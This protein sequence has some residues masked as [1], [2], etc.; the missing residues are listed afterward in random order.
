VSGRNIVVTV[1][2]EMQIFDQQVVTARLALE[3][4][5]DLLKRFGLKLST[6]RKGPSAFARPNMSCWPVRPTSAWGLLL[7]FTLPSS[8]RPLLR[9]RLGAYHAGKLVI[10]R[11]ILT[12]K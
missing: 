1:L 2:N 10:A 4:L 8:L 11:Q 9:L 7:H 12:G 5:A 6:L 3:K